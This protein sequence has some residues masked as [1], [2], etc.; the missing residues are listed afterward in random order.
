MDGFCEIGGFA[1]AAD[2][3]GFAIIVVF[4]LEYGSWR[5]GGNVFFIVCLVFVGEVCLIFCVKVLGL[6]GALVVADEAG[7]DGL[8]FCF[9]IL[10]AVVFVGAGVVLTADGVLGVLFLI[11]FLFTV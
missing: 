4:C 1:L 2:L 5:I 8:G 3:V 9:V 7:H 6:D 10:L 11:G